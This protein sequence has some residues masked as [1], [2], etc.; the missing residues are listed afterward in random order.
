MCRREEIFLINLIN[1]WKEGNNWREFG[2][3]LMKK[4]N[5]IGVKDDIDWLN[6]NG[7]KNEW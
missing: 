7:I 6:G 2:C 3:K 1:S 4:M 5:R